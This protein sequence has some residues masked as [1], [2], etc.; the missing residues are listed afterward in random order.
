VP[1][2]EAA[3]EIALGRPIAE[4]DE[5]VR[6]RLQEF[7][8]ALA[9]APMGELP[10]TSTAMLPPPSTVPGGSADGSGTS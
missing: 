5:A 7:A 3:I 8:D 10:P 4:V 2:V 9:K 6:A 1:T